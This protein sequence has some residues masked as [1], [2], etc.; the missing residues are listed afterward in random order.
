MSS[1]IISNKSD[2]RDLFTLLE[3]R[4]L[5]ITVNIKKGKDRSVDQNRLQRLWVNEAAEQGDMTAE[6]YRGYCKLHFGCAILYNENP[7][8]A[9][10]FDEVIRPLSYEHKLK[11]MMIPLDMP[12]SRLMTTGQCK[13]Y[14]DDMWHHFTSLGMKLTD[15]DS[16]GLAA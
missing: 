8:F 2:L 5:P 13:R 10:A 9:E 1:H 3:N 6:E 15:P 7:E 16:L 11:A 14:L 4:K 12:V